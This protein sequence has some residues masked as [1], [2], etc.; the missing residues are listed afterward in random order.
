MK[1]EHAK[2]PDMAATPP[3]APRLFH[4]FQLSP[5]RAAAAQ[6]LLD[7]HPDIVVTSPKALGYKTSPRKLPAA[8]IKRL[9]GRNDPLIVELGAHH[10]EDT[11]EFLNTFDNCLVHA[12]ECDPRA[13]TAFQIQVTDRRCVLHK[14]AVSSVDGCCEL[15][16]SGGQHRSHAEASDWDH[17]SSILRPTGHL[18]KHAWCKFNNRV[19]VPQLSLST[20]WRCNRHRLP[21]VVDFIW[22]DIQGAEYL[23]IAGG[24]DVLER[25]RYFYAEF[26]STALYEGQKNLNELMSLLGDGWELLGVYESCNLLAVNRNVSAYQG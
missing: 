2:Q 26:D 5:P 11:Q 1:A 12:F 6:R 17:S 16:Q 25:T 22:A 13:L 4:P 18:V 7:T 19:V 10:G 21:G 20:W 23:A 14:C 8:E 24:R 9:V 15:H 3:I